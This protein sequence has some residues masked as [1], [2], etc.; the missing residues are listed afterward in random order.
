LIGRCRTI[1]PAESKTATAP[2][3]NDTRSTASAAP[4]AFKAAMPL[5]ITVR[6]ASAS[7]PPEGWA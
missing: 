7:S 2:A 4:T 1:R 3:G 6:K 5:A